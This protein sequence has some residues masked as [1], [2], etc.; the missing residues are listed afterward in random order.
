MRS[1]TLLI[2]TKVRPKTNKFQSETLRNTDLFSEKTFWGACKPSVVP[3]EVSISGKQVD[4]GLPAQLRV[5][6]VFNTIWMTSS[7]SVHQSVSNF[8]ILA[9]FWLYSLPSALT[10]LIKLLLIVSS[11]AWKDS[12]GVSAQTYQHVSMFLCEEIIETGRQRSPGREPGVTQHSWVSRRFSTR[13]TAKDEFCVRQGTKNA[14]C[15][16]GG[17]YTLHTLPCLRDLQLK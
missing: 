13:E 16:L 8:W 11:H 15:L 14:L 3:P 4:R 17:S 7:T 5:K 10:L 2:S 12:M 6:E 1:E 9:V